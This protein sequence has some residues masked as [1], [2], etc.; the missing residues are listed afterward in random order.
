M[1][2][3]EIV[4]GSEVG[5]IDEVQQIGQ[6]KKNSKLS[7]KQGTIKQGQVNRTKS[8]FYTQFQQSAEG[9]NI[10]ISTEKDQHK[11]KKMFSTDQN[12]S[13]ICRDR[14]EISVTRGKR[15]ASLS[16]EKIQI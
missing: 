9:R 16:L 7:C 3:P 14:G 15:V 11:D 6:K 8:H 12:N 13:S 1:K 10:K 2:E 5:Q 4:A